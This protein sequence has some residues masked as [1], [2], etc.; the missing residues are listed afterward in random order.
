M[1]AMHLEL[2]LAQ[3][4]SAICYL[5]L[6]YPYGKQRNW[7]LLSYW[8]ETL[9]STSVKILFRIK[10]SSEHSGSSQVNSKIVYGI[11]GMEWPMV[12]LAMATVGT[13]PGTGNLMIL[14]KGADFLK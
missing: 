2:C 3:Q 1:Y 12:W 14:T 13:D 9:L 4:V 8:V 5:V 10:L 11:P 7:G 6:R